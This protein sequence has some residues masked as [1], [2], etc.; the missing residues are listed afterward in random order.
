M[1]VRE[2]LEG[3]N[4]ANGAV[5]E[6][7]GEEE[8]QGVVDDGKERSN[9]GSDSPPR[10]KTKTENGGVGLNA[11]GGGAAATVATDPL[12]LTVAAAMGNLISKMHNCNIIHGDLT[13]SNV[14]LGKDPPPPNSINDKWSPSLTLIDFGL[15]S[16]TGGAKGKGGSAAATASLAGASSIHEE[17]AVDL[18]VLERAFAATHPHSEALVK[19]MLRAYKADSFTG[20][21]VLQR[22][23][24]VRLRGRKRDCFG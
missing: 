14:I 22:L 8:E 18:F 6:S 13:T 5:S 23:A 19:E 16:Q 21:S 11:N 1:T 3:R 4:F 20:D 10:K 7:E 12:A 2:F 15:A 17:K 9:G 24:Q